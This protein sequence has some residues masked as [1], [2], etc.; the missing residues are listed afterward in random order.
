MAG[1]ETGANRTRIRWAGLP[2]ARGIAEVHV[3]AWRS[4]YRGLLPD[5]T[6]EQLSVE[7]V[8]ARWEGRLTET[9]AQVLVLSHDEQVVGF[10]GYGPTDDE[11]ADPENVGE[12]YVLYVAPE[13]WRRGHGT[14][15]L[16]EAMD[17]LRAKGNTEAVLWVLHDNAQ[18]IA[19]YESAGFVADGVKRV[20]ER[21]DGTR[22]IVARYRRRF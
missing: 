6:L 15:L 11:D 4:A 2:D 1:S 13:E 16:R 22:M 3:A 10:V 21:A 14:A 9:W 5:T 17:R 20:K 12:I 8:N 19:F 7:D 18:A